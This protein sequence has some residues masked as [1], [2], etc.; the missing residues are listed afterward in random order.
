MKIVLPRIIGHSLLGAATGLAVIGGNH[1]GSGGV[2][3]VIAG[4]L[5]GWIWARL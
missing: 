4:M 1:G 5:I 2:A 3:C